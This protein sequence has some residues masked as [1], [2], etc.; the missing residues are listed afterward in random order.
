MT[1]RVRVPS[2]RLATFGGLVLA[3]ALYLAIG[4]A[5][6]AAAETTTT[7]I[8]D[9]QRGP[10]L[11]FSCTDCHATIKDNLVPGHIFTH[12]A[13]MTYDCTACHPR[14]PHTRAGTQRPLMTACFS[15]HG[16]RH[17]PQGIIA[18]A[19]CTKCHVKP[20]AQL[21]PK[22]HLAPDF[23]GKGHVAPSK[24]ML[25]TN[26]M[27]CH[28]Q[29]QCDACHFKAK[30]SWETTLTYAYDAGNGCLSCHKTVLPRLAAPVTAST[31][32]SSAH[33]DLTCAQCHPDFRYNDGASA[34]KLWNVN[35]GLACGAA[36]CHP[37]ERKVWAV[38]VHGAAVLS[39]SITNGATCSGCH[40][41]HNIERLKTQGAKNRLRL[42][43]GTTCVGSCH[44]H[45]AAV[46][47]YA[48]WW[49][50]SGYKAG[51]LDAPAC[52]TCHGAHE[53]KALKDPA[54]TTSPEVLPK[55]CGQT[56]CHAGA[57]E[58]FV[59]PWRTLAHGR[60]KAVETNPLAILRASLF[61]GGR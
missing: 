59:E 1:A 53:T 2:R 9:L 47:S 30:V 14:F 10:L 25:R 27:M 4:V 12:G 6:A 57:T 32:D 7:P 24:A 54:S 35:A 38:S 23:N 56:G 15:C 11:S 39:G 43:G 3:L 34:T 36:G 37:K 19:D 55:T 60:V 18:G 33:R 48:D 42:S 31:L 20:R 5:P 51:S 40:G 22:D 16:L 61:P 58:A 21:I 26:C 8:Q 28:T 29:A 45:Q 46:A 13:H 44:T 17:G 50:G 52:W 41:G 49:H